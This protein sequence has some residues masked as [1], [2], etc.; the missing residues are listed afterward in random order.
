[1]KIKEE[2]GIEEKAQ[3]PGKRVERVGVMSGGE[4]AIVGI[5]ILLSLFGYRASPFCVLD[6]VDAALDEMN[7][8]RMRR[9]LEEMS[10]EKEKEK[11]KGK[12]KGKEKSK[13][14][15]REV[16]EG[17]GVQFVVITHSKR[18]MESAQRMY[19]ATMEEA[20][21]TKIVGVK[22]GEERRGEER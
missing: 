1:M 17:E 4:K 7:I 20:G 10:K 5:V 8:E 2:I 21:V 18:T 12:E 15:E 9:K 22:I 3:A 14:K 19:G 6:E 13:E 16:E 11:E